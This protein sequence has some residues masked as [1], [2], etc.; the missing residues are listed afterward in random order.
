MDRAEKIRGKMKGASAI[1]FYKTRR[2][3]YSKKS[4]STVQVTS[5]GA[6]NHGVD[7]GMD[8][9]GVVVV[10]DE[11]LEGEI[12]RR[13]SK[14]RDVE[15][16]FYQV[17]TQCVPALTAIARPGKPRN[18]LAHF[19][20][21]ATC[22]P[23]FDKH[24]ITPCSGCTVAGRELVA[25]SPAK[26]RCFRLKAGTGFAERDAPVHPDC[27][28]TETVWNITDDSGSWENVSVFVC[29]ASLALCLLQLHMARMGQKKQVGG[30]AL[31]DVS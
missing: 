14:R 19:S 3:K 1:Q 25:D 5:A 30:F 28:H 29:F 23:V 9:V 8:V 24:L 6:E 20:G 31:S 17:K 7:M 18:P 27:N 13:G 21:A 4:V 16:H 12:G 15:T 26:R 10:A 22:R 2:D 11:K